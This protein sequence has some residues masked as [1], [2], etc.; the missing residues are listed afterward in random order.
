MQSFVFGYKVL[1]FSLHKK[2]L[3]SAFEVKKKKQPAN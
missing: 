1:E 2:E 3:S